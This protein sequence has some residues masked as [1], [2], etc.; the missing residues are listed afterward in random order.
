MQRAENQMTGFAGVEHN[1]HRF[2]VAD[3]ADKNDFWCLPHGG[4]HASVKTV[5]ITP[6]FPLAERGLDRRKHK[7]NR[8]FQREDVDISGLVDFVQYGSHCGRLA[9]TRA[10]GYK[11]D[12]VFFLD[13]LLECRGQ[14]ERFKGRN[15]RLKVAQHHGV[16]SILNVNVDAKPARISQGITAIA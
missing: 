15:Q 7:F 6:Q 1:F 16:I 3:F 13:D 12:T 5:K 4:A 11:D 8:I 14:V 10:T 2:A 9:H